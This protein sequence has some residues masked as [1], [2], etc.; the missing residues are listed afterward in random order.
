MSAGAIIMAI[1]GFVILF[2]GTFY[3]LSKMKKRRKPET[4]NLA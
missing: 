4:K 3:G 2:G 1:L